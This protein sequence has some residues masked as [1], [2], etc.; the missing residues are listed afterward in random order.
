LDSIVRSA[1]P[2]RPTSVADPAQFAWQ[3]VLPPVF[4]G[5]PVTPAELIGTAA[6]PQ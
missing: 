6:F 1:N 2:V 3:P 5:M 4:M